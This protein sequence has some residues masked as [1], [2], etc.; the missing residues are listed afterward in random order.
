MNQRNGN[1]EEVPTGFTS[2]DIDPIRDTRSGSG[3]NTAPSNF[4]AT[5]EA[6]DEDEEDAGNS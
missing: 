6:D 4:G 5:V 1:N 3:A 2:T